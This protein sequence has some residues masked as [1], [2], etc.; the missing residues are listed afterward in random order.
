M[1][2]FFAGIYMVGFAM[3]MLF[4]GT[5]VRPGNSLLFVFFTI[6][7][8]V[9]MTFVLIHYILLMFG[10]I[11]RMIHFLNFSGKRPKRTHPKPF[12]RGGSV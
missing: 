11:H 8:P 4:F 6:V 2:E 1:I 7:W 10:R 5:K 9:S 3:S 12:R